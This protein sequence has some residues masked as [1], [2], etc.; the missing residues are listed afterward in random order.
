MKTHVI[1]WCFLILAIG[2][3]VVSGCRSHDD[4]TGK[5]ATGSREI[6]VLY[7]VTVD[8]LELIGSGI[9]EVLKPRGWRI[10]PLSAEGDPSKFPAIVET[11]LAMKSPV[12]V[13]V[14]TQITETALG[15]RY[16]RSRPPLVAAAVFEPEKLSSFA[17][18]GTAPPRRLQVAIVSDKTQGAGSRLISLLKDL[19]PQ[20]RTIGILANRAE[21]NSMS[22]AEEVSGA[23]RQA[24]LTVEMGYLSGPADLTPVTRALLAR[25]VDALV[26]PHDKVAVAQATTVVELGLKASSRPVPV[27]SL[28]D[29][30]VR[31][32]GVLACVSADYHAIGRITGE[33]ALRALDGQPLATTEIARPNSLLVLLNRKTASRLGLG[34]PT[35]LDGVVWVE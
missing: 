1:R 18:G 3:L 28:D 15:A 25:G 26:I 32:H 29:G 9:S 35:A 31:K 27:L 5:A 8:S 4:A 14:G 24:N 34:T 19:F 30:T 21:A 2:M 13:S 12:I 22:S 6:P 20:A 7:P 17:Q 16:A 10:R 11:A 23:A 33:L